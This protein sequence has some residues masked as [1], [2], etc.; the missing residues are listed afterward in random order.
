MTPKPFYLLIDTSIICSYLVSKWVHAFGD[1]SGF[2]GVIV[3]EDPQSEKLINAR[4]DF[5]ER[6][7]SV[8][9]LTDE[10][11]QALTEL[12][13]SLD[14][15]EQAMIE[16]YGV[17]KYSAT[18]YQKTIFIGDNLN[19][20]RAKKWLTEISESSAPSIFVCASQILKSWWIDLT[21]SQIFNC[22][23]AVLPYARGMYA[24]ENMAIQE[25]INQFSK[26]AGSTVHY[27]DRG[28]DTGAIIRAQRIINP[29][30]FD[31]IWHLKAH[32]YLLGFDLYVKTAQDILADSQT[33]PV[34]T[35]V[36]PESLGPN[37]RAKEFTPEK[38][39][40]AEKSYL[41]MKSSV[42]IS[43]HG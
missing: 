38:Q 29:F 11:Y 8:N 5:H 1:L 12:Y 22:H 26:A 3:K 6:Y 33:I 18:G 7:F 2:Q 16:D 32:S 37:F 36:N 17:A 35:V 41:S 30:Q 23:S 21:Q 34:G 31:S 24:I 25:D 10:S 40:Q 4:Q 20:S 14:R 19:G 42:E 43:I 13:P 15:T 9:H 28:V 39:R 27:L